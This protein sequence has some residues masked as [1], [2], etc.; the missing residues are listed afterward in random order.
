MYRST[1]KFM[2]SLSKTQRIKSPIPID[3]DWGKAVNDAKTYWQECLASNLPIGQNSLGRKLEELGYSPEFSK[4]VAETVSQFYRAVNQYEPV[5]SIESKNKPN[6]SIK[7]EKET[8][9]YTCTMAYLPK[10]LS[11]KVL[12]IALEIGDANLYDPKDEDHRFGRENEPHITVKFGTHTDD[13]EDIKEAL[14]DMWPA[15]VTLGRISTFKN[16]DC[17]VI[18]I[19]VISDDLAEANKRISKKCKCTDTHPEYKPHITIAYVTKGSCEYLEGMK[20]L[21]GVEVVFDEF[22]FQGKT[23]NRTMIPL[24]GTKK[25]VEKK[26]SIH[27]LDEKSGKDWFG[28]KLEA[29]NLHQQVK[30]ELIGVL[31]DVWK[32]S[33]KDFNRVDMVLSAADEICRTV[34]AEEIISISKFNNERPRLCA[35][36]IYCMLKD[37]IRKPE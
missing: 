32:I 20:N 3:E 8:Y 25:T 18:K 34:Q 17:D 33:E 27:P 2:R 9:D 21:D 28:I 12:K 4:K 36:R 29:G 19:D 7:A 10:D 16:E 37:K 31:E 22:A 6:I 1:V 13:P 24:L 30:R 26:S 11:E 23:G 35:E 14:K 15:K 5:A